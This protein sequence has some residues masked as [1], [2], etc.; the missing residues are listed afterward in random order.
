MEEAF[1]QA[2]F[3][4]L[5]NPAPSTL[6][7]KGF[8]WPPVSTPLACSLNNMTNDRCDTVV[9]SVVSWVDIIKSHFYL[10]VL[11]ESHPSQMHK[12]MNYL[13]AQVSSC[14]GERCLVG[15]E[16]GRSQTEL[17]AQPQTGFLVLFLLTPHIWRMY[18]WNQIWTSSTRQLP[19]CWTQDNDVK[20]KWLCLSGSPQFSWNKHHLAVPSRV[21]RHYF[22]AFGPSCWVNHCSEQWLH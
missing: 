2:G 7:W 4:K 22:I 20:E 8:Y 16:D 11:R 3:W 14:S 6:W 9:F 5:R 1:K 15:R 10:A 21:I 18:T 19:T 13:T 17:V 12:E